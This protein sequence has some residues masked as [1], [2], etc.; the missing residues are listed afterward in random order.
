[1]AAT[2]VNA[3]NADQG[4]E[5]AQAEAGSLAGEE[6]ADAATHGGASGSEPAEQ[7]VLGDL[8]GAP[9]WCEVLTLP[10]A[11]LFVA[12]SLLNPPA[13]LASAA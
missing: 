9:T 13:I 6:P 8:Q 1:M 2:I 11:M 12:S 3:V 5:T 4:A 10:L 7:K